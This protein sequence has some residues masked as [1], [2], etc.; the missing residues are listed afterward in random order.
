MKKLHPS[1]FF[2]LP[3]LLAALLPLCG[4]ASH[5]FTEVTGHIEYYGNAPFAKPAFKA[6]DG[7]L[8]QMVVSE[9]ADF[10]LD[11]ILALQGH[12]L[13]LDGTISDA[14]LS[15]FPIGAQKKISI[16]AWQEITPR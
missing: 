5:S 7:T 14:D 16:H 15:A 3:L 2:F 1:P 13:C 6:D 11:D 9:D 10:V 12:H 8:Y 4:M